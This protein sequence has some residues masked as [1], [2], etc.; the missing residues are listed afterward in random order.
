MSKETCADQKY[1]KGT[2]KENCFCVADGGKEDGSVLWYLV[3]CPKCQKRPKETYIHEK[4][5]TKE[6]Y[7]YVFDGGK[8]DGGV[9]W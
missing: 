3:M 2:T 4:R 9:L 1:E 8:E 7:F 5:T 6:N